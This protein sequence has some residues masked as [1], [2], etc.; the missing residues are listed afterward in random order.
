MAGRGA[1]ESPA[2]AVRPVA[3]R[4]VACAAALDNQAT[5]AVQTLS[6]LE[7]HG[8]LRWLGARPAGAT[9]RSPRSEPGRAVRERA[10]S[11]IAA[12]HV[13]VVVS[14]Q[15]HPEPRADI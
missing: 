4:C 2:A 3:A 15:V 13:E 1:A 5:R 10:L 9:G 7:L 11:G 12:C 6:V 8:C 14:L